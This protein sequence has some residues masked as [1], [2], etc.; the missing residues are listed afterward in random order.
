MSEVGGCGVGTILVSLLSGLIGAVLATYLN[1]HLFR[2]HHRLSLKRDVLVRLVGNRHLFIGSLRTENSEP[3]VS[4]NQAFVVFEDSAN[5][6]SALKD[7]H[8]A[9]GTD[10][11]GSA[12]D[13]MVTLIK[14]MAKAS[15]IG[16]NNLNDSFLL[17]PFT[18]GSG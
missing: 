16:I 5:V 11:T 13:K 9:T 3:F 7:L 10:G 6:I 14:A 1:S 2:K 15:G 8:G 18:P 17:T 4:L 12:D